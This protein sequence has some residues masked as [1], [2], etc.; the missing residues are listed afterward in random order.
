MKIEE[1]EQEILNLKAELV[2]LEVEIKACEDT[3]ERKL[4]RAEKVK[5]QGQLEN[6]SSI[7]NSL[8]SQR[9]KNKLAIINYFLIYF[10]GNYYFFSATNL[11]QS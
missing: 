7:L 1:V 5:M 8:I 4:L 9:G 11:L 6:W 10:S 3:E 2:K